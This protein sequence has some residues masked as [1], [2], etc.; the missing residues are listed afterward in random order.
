M[1]DT[2][3]HAVQ[4]TGLAGLAAALS[5]AVHP[6]NATAADLAAGKVVFNNNCAAC[7]GGGGN[8]VIADRTLQKEAIEKYLEG[9]FK[10]EAIIYQVEN[11]KG[12]M[13]AWVGRLD[14]EE[15]VNVA[16]YVYSVASK[17]GWANE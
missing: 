12:A 15:I 7:H 6:F 17:N 10:V 16:N 11:G 8:S 4:A 5:I 1:C 13:P 14:E 9:G 3:H 2:H